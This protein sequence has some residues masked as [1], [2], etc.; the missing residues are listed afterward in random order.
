MYTNAYIQN[1]ARWYQIIYL[2][3][4]NGET[5]IENRLMDRG[6]GEERVRC[7]DRVT[8][9]LILSYVKQ[10]ANG[11]LLCLRKLKQGFCDNL[12][13]WDGEGDVWIR[14]YCRKI[15]HLHLGAITLVKW[16]RPL[17]L[18]QAEGRRNTEG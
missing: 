13:G 3:G 18:G 11:Y 10:I 14:F 12:K 15:K 1:L 5:D 16:Q 17:E 6:R 2:Q 8:W 4:S 9:K 7:M